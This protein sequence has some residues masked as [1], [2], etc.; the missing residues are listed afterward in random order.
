MSENAKTVAGDQL[1]LI[2]VNSVMTKKL[3]FS[4]VNVLSAAGVKRHITP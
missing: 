2:N 1:Q 3:D 4:L